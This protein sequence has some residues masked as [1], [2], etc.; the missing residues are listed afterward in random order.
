M[1]VTWISQGGY[2][3]EVDRCRLVVDPYLSD[4]GEVTR[5]L[6]RLVPPPFTA[7]QLQP[8]VVVCTHDHLDHFD[9]LLIPELDRIYRGCTFVGPESV[10]RHYAEVGI[11]AERTVQLAPRDSHTLGPFQLSATVAYHS[12]PTSVGL[13]IEA[14][15]RI[16]YVSGDTE[17][18]D[19]LAPQVAQISRGEIDV[20]FI[21]INGRMKNMN[22]GEALQVVRILDPRLVVPMH[23]GLFAENTVDPEPFLA[24]CRHAGLRAMAL[25]LG[26]EMVLKNIIG[27]LE[28]H[29]S[30]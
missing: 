26:R 24:D 17:Y 7:E 28:R 4:Y 14:A 11:G 16:L 12:D 21:C 27:E 8:D 20:V 18:R 2:I 15:G 10:V 3:C 6:T 22:A 5:G 1:R 9:P 23:Y 25:P 30:H 29:E 13:V 19:D